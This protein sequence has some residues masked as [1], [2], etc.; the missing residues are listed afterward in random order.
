MGRSDVTVTIRLDKSTY[1]QL[2]STNDCGLFSTIPTM[3]AFVV[4]RHY[5]HILYG[6]SFFD[7][8]LDK[9]YGDDEFPMRGSKLGYMCQMLGKAELPEENQ[10]DEENILIKKKTKDVPPIPIRITYDFATCI[11]KFIENTGFYK[12]R[13]QFCLDALRS[14]INE[15]STLNSLI[16][17]MNNIDAGTFREHFD[18]VM[19]Y[20][21]RSPT[22]FRSL[23]TSKPST[24]ADDKRWLDGPTPLMEDFRRKSEEYRRMHPEE[25][26][27]EISSDANELD[28]PNHKPSED[29]P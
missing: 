8:I 13:T 18:G 27:S 10:S 14:W 6:I 29:R 20:L 5:Y 23:H 12:N 11:D 9:H 17:G 3:C 15:H 24:L 25:F 7:V 16:N 22:Y 21:F 1:E 4:R 26:T 28:K 19:Y 2:K